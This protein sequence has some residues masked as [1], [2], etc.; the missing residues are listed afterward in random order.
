VNNLHIIAL[1]KLHN[2]LCCVSSE[3]SRTCRAWRMCQAVL[4]QH[5][6][7]RRSSS[8]CVYKFSFFCFVCTCKE[9]E[10]R[11]HAVWVKDYLRKRETFGYYNSLLMS[12]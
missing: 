4:F 8:A 3:S 9:K 1:Y 6:G 12:N 5:G 11:Q 10:K 2:K 7:G